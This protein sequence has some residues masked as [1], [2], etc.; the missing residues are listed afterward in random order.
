MLDNLLKKDK[1]L[2][3]KYEKLSYSKKKEINKLL[4]GSK[5]EET[6]LK[7]FKK[8]IAGINGKN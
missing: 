1:Q 8:V 5:K 2:S 6:L 3:E 7:N 4:F